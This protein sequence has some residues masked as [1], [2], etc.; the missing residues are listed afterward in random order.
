MLSR[1]PLCTQGCRG[2]SGSRRGEAQSLA[3]MPT[4]PG[5]E[6]GLL[7]RD[8]TLGGQT[9]RKWPPNPSPNAQILPST[10]ESDMKQIM[11]LPSPPPAYYRASDGC[12]RAP[13]SAALSAQEATAAPTLS[14]AHKYIRSSAAPSP[15]L[16][17]L[18]ADVLG[19]SPVCQLATLSPS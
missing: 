11:A 16:E 13:G 2:G 5:S 10:T 9:M 4:G 14:L 8:D 6:D 18:R 7:R 15:W 1:S 17:G 12:N 19:F 3:S